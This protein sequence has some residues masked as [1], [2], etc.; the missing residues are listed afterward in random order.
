MVLYLNLTNVQFAFQN[1]LCKKYGQ[2]NSCCFNS[3]VL[4]TFLLACHP[5][6]PL[7]AL[8]P[9]QCVSWRFYSILRLLFLFV[10]QSISSHCAASTLCCAEL[11]IFEGHSPIS[12]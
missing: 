9:M 2:K 11:T 6:S 1:D 10:D 12:A 4:S 8:P 5:H 3:C 7:I